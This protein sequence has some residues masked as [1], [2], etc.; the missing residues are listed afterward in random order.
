MRQEHERKQREAAAQA[1]RE[2]QE[3]LERKREE[4]RAE[5]ERLRKV[6]LLLQGRCWAKGWYFAV[7]LVGPA[8]K[9]WFGLGLGACQGHAPC[10]SV[11]RRCPACLYILNVHP[12]WPAFPQITSRA[13]LEQPSGF[14]TKHRHLRMAL[15]AGG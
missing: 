2:R 12:L 1:E 3:A 9:H 8:H 11:G 14:C 5:A 7:L 4:E 10:Q 13:L 6:W 15:W